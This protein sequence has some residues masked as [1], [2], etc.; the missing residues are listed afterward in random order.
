MSTEAVH[1]A[2]GEG[3]GGGLTGQDA[4]VEACAPDAAA[5]GKQAVSSLESLR[6]GWKEEGASALTLADLDEAPAKQAHKGWIYELLFPNGKGYVGQT[7]RW[8]KRMNAHRRGKGRDDGHLIKRAIRKYGWDRVDVRVLEEVPVACL[9]DAEVRWITTRGTMKPNGYNTTPGGDAQPMDDADVRARHRR[10][11][12]KAMRTP[13]TREKKRALWRDEGYR[14]MQHTKRSE[15]EAWQ[16]A[17]RDCQNSAGAIEKRRATWARKRAEKI[18]TMGVEEGRAFM[19]RAMRH[20]LRL[21]RGASQRVDSAYGR[22]PVRETREFWE[23]EIAGYEATVW[24][25]TLAS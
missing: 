16:Q 13:E 4:L 20:A 8:K 7:R 11:I 3:E 14:Q 24:R 23:K 15:S 18:V 19:T 6:A 1:A 25:R 22:D 10:E 17:R 2:A 12:G 5:Q 9:N 21:A